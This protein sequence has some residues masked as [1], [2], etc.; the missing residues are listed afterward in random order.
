[1]ETNTKILGKINTQRC[2]VTLKERI[3]EN[4]VKLFVSR[5]RDWKVRMHR[6]HIVFTFPFFLQNII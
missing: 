4:L 6:Y 2:S 5:A 3:L 1:M